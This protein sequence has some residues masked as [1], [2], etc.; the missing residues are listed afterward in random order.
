MGFRVLR[1]RKTEKVFSEAT[2]KIKEN[3]VF[4][5]TAVEGDGPV[6]AL[7]MFAALIKFYPSL[8][9]VKL[10]DFKVRVLDG[11]M[12]RSRRSGCLLSHQMVSA[13]GEL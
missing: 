3:D 1:R 7:I 2:I 10:E 8:S 13:V 11:R 9:K 6:N 5:H 4:E 12:A